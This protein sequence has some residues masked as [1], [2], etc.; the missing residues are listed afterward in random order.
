MDRITFHYDT[1]LSDVHMLLPNARHLMSRLNR[2]GQPVF[3][4]KFK[5]LSDSER[6]GTE[7]TEVTEAGGDT[8]GQDGGRVEASVDEDGDFEITHRPRSPPE[9]SGRDPVCPVILHQSDPGQ[10][11]QEE[12][13]EEDEEEEEGEVVIRIEH[14]MA[15]PLED[16]GKQVWRGACLLADFILSDPGRF[17]GDTV[18]ELG[19]GT[20]LTSITMATAAKTVYC[21]DVGEDLLSM[22]ERNVALNK[23]VMEASGGQVKVR[24]LDWLQQDLP[25]DAE[26]EFSWTEAE[27][28]DLYD[29]TSVIIAA[30][31][32]YDDE[33]TDGLFRTLQRLCSHFSHTCTV[34][35]SLERRMNF[36]LRHMDVSCEAYDH[37]SR[38]LSQL[39]EVEDDRCSFSVQRLPVDFPQFLLYERIEQLE[40]WR[41]TSTPRHARDHH[42][43]DHHARDPHARDHHARDHHARVAATVDGPE[44]SAQTSS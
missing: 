6:A 17:R 31:V 35:F 25:T 28:E 1:V 16:V 41:V 32:C 43:R 40:L 37:F 9:G 39:E 4:S 26:V 20:G 15:T 36:T 38:C 42:A 24:H 29:N 13:E 19:A 8:R 2:V 12:E 27:V 33:L 21:T 22:C 23:H 34:L 10:E 7:L 30:D 14:T 18:L 44:V 5:I 11:E 3:I